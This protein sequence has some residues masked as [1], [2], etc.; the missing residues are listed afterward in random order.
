MVNTIYGI[1][2]FIFEGIFNLSAIHL[3][4]TDGMKIRETRTSGKG[5]EKKIIAFRDEGL[6][7]Q[8][9]FKLYKTKSIKFQFEF[10]E[11]E[12]SLTC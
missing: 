12:K 7:K 10:S 9:I 1:L 6:L 4:L 5:K 2:I 11:K 3:R 8:K